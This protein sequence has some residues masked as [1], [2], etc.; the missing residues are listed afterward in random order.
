MYTHIASAGNL[1]DFASSII[2]SES[3]VQAFNALARTSAEKNEPNLPPNG[4]ETEIFADEQN[5]LYQHMFRYKCVCLGA[6]RPLST[7]MWIQDL[8]S[9]SLVEARRL[10]SPPSSNFRFTPR[11]IENK[12]SSLLF[13]R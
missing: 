5:G 9:R 1:I 3:Q 11:I 6:V 10:L 8:G 12:N 2:V 4:E 7:A 13:G